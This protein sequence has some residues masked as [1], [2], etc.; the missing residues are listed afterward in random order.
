MPSHSCKVW[1]WFYVKMVNR[2]SSIVL[3]YIRSYMLLFRFRG[4]PARVPCTYIRC[5][6]VY[7]VPVL[8]GM[9]Q[10]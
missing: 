8:T 4:A 10:V 3:C 2:L 1:H 7:Q 9:Y 6:R 5:A